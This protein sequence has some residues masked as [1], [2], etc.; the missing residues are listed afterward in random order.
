MIHRSRY[1]LDLRNID[2]LSWVFEDLT[3]A[4]RRIIFADAE[5]D[6]RSLNAIQLQTLTKKI[7]RG[8]SILAGVGRGDVVLAYAYNS[9][10]YPALVLGTLC[11]GAVF[12]GADYSYKRIGMIVIVE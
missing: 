1:R 8:L 9:Y 6:S 11:A 5:D 12:S 2:I 3:T 7:G 10:L 4:P